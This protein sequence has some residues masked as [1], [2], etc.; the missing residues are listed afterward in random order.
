MLRDK[1]FFPKS[2]SSTSG[3]ATRSN[4]AF[5]DASSS[6]THSNWYCVYRTKSKYVYKPCLLV[7]HRKPVQISHSHLFIYSNKTA[8]I[9]HELSSHACLFGNIITGLEIPLFRNICIC[10]WTSEIATSCCLWDNL[11]V[12]RQDL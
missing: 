8:L 3:S 7:P 4:T 5:C 9:K 1:P 12:C 2:T 6:N 10:H 11:T